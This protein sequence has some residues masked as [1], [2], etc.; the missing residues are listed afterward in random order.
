MS[1]STAEINAGGALEGLSIQERLKQRKKGN[2]FHPI[3]KETNF[4]SIRSFFK[5][6]T[7]VSVKVFFTAALC[8]GAFQSYRF[9]TESKYFAISKV[10]FAGQNYLL[11]QNLEELLGP[12][13]G[14]S[15]FLQD[16]KVLENNLEAHPWI[17]TVSLSRRFPNTIYAQITERT[18][19][20]RIQLGKDYLM[21][22]SG[23]LLDKATSEHSDLP[24]ITGVK[25]DKN[26]FGE[27]VANKD[28][29][30]AV[31]TMHNLNGLKFFLDDPFT[32]VHI[33]KDYRLTFTSGIRGIKI[34]MTIG[35]IDEGFK[36]LNLILNAIKSKGDEIQHID[37]S[38]KDKVVIK[39]AHTT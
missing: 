23:V 37:L 33:K 30:R 11:G 15:I 21:D 4:D 7:V 38:F 22:K 24:M 13:G 6:L 31:Q 25:T 32:S 2:S 14:T 36:N 1:Y 9:V 18:P 12:I 5:T 28:V 27:I 35:T 3:H 16:M 10:T 8:Y 26:K 34:H 39:E 20:A 17:E 29:I 19:Y